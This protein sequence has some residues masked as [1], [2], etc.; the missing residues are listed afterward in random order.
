MKLLFFVL[1]K[2][3]QLDA[4]LTEFANRSI[5]GATILDSMGMARLLS[6]EHNED[7]IPFLGTLRTFLNP[8]RQKSNLIL[9]VL[10]DERVAEAV[11][12]IESVVG[13]LSE[14]DTGIVFSLPIDF[15]KGL[16]GIGK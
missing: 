15:A 8:A 6:Q 1:N 12:A 11:D 7:E 2:T 9:T 14:K 5:G 10:S 16:C 13:D 4:V 3:D